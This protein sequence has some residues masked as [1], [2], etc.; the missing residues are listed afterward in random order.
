MNTNNNTN[1]N[2]NKT[3]NKKL[4]YNMRKLDESIQDEIRK[5]KIVRR[6]RILASERLGGYANKWDMYLLWM[7]ILS[8][9]L[10]VISLLVKDE[11]LIRKVVS[12]CFSLY[13][14]IIQYYVST[15]NYRERALKFHYHHIEINKLKE[16]LQG[17]SNHEYNFKTR[18]AKFKVIVEKYNLLLQQQENH[19]EY[20]YRR[21]KY[22]EIQQRDFSMENIFVN[23]QPLFILLFILAYCFLGEICNGITI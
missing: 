8:S 23:I 6:A 21:A 10:L 22:K 9:A 3:N 5:L 20:D 16:S 15:L 7:A 18:N 13:T 14:V 4:K 1:S 19:S 12:G 11:G 2:K 17:L